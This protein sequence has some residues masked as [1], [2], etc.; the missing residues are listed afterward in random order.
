MLKE[1]D[2]D[3]HAGLIVYIP[4]WIYI[5]SLRKYKEIDPEILSRVLYNGTRAYYTSGP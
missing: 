3:M 5:K 1:I 4:S 2:Q